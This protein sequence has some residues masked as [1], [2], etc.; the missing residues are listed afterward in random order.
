MQ[1]CLNLTFSLQEESYHL[2]NSA[3]NEQNETI[4]QDW[5][6][7]YVLAIMKPLFVSMQYGLTV[8]GGVFVCLGLLSV[9]QHGPAS[10]HTLRHAPHKKRS[11]MF[12]HRISMFYRLGLGIALLLLTLLDIGPFWTDTDQLT[13]A[14]PIFH[15]A[16]GPT[17]LPMIFLITLSAALVDFVR[18]ILAVP[19]GEV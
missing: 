7:E 19:R 13:P 5:S 17:Y 12:Y 9:L 4:S 6:N 1:P 2:I 18:T 15:L 16:N 3:L 14:A 8:L 11:H 10:F